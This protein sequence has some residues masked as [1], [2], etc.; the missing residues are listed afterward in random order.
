MIS[1]H[2]GMN[3]DSNVLQ[4]NASIDGVGF[5][6]SHHTLKMVAMTSFH[7]EK[8]CNLLSAHE[9]SA[10]CI[11]SSIRQFLISRTNALAV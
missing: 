3:S 9:A 2:I 4:V 11:C 7:T 5:S 8:C 6:I 1:N 10:M